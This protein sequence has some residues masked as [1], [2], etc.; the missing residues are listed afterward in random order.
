MRKRFTAAWTK[1]VRHYKSFDLFPDYWPTMAEHWNS[2]VWGT[3]PVFF[4]LFGVWLSFGVP[5]VQLVVVGI[6]WAFV[7]AGY[8][9]WRA[10]HLRLIPGIKLE[11][12]RQQPAP[13]AKGATCTYIQLVMACATEAPIEECKGRLL[14][15]WRWSDSWEEIQPNQPLRLNWSPGKDE[16]QPL[17][18]GIPQLIDV[19]FISDR[20]PHISFCSDWVPQRAKTISVEQP[21]LLKFEVAVTGKDADSHKSLP[22]LLILFKVDIQRWPAIDSI[23]QL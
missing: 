6:V 21:S 22:T 4:L 8:Y 18:P 20:D 17:F 23:E 2:I 3:G 5:P 7:V 1:I 10:D 16:P 12:I 14:H 11:E 9:T 15:V 19:F 13:A